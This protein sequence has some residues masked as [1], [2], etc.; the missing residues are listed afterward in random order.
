MSLRHP[1]SGF[2][3]LRL[4]RCVAL[5]LA[6]FLLGSA[7]NARA[8]EDRD[9]PFGRS[10]FYIGLG[11][12]YQWNVFENRIEDEVVDALEDE[13]PAFVE[14]GLDLEDSYGANAT[15]GYRVFSFFAI[16]AEY[17]WVSKYDVTLTTNVDGIDARLYSIEGHTLTANTKWILP[18]WRIQPYLLVGGG[19]AIADVD[20]GGIYDDP[21]LGPGLEDNGVKV[22]DGR[23]TSLA[24]RAG[25]GLD[26]YL[27][28]GIVVNAEAGA[29]VTTLEMPDLGDIDDL[30]YLSFTGGLQYRF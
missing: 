9:R 4:R 13:V 25:L 17:E 20:R 27:T 3:F 30:N 15:I 5:A 12:S 29:V 10:G 22:H 7:A 18:T 14:L 2:G 23:Q 24:G 6:G 19:V 8:E 28:R 16:E 11:G 1:D 21:I 26:L